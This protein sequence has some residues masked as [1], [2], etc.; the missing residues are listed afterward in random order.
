MRGTELTPSRWGLPEESFIYS[1]NSLAA[2]KIWPRLGL[3][4]KVHAAQS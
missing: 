3:L 4:I 2:S 1:G